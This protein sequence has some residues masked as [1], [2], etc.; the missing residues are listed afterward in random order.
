MSGVEWI[1]L[2]A[3]MPSGPSS[4]RVTLWRRM[5]AAGA[6]SL[7]N[8][9]WALPAS[10]KNELFMNEI[11]TYVREHSGS[12][13]IFSARALT[14]DVE[15]RIIDEFSKNIAEDYVEFID[16]C[17]DFLIEIDGEIRQKKF[18]FAELDENEA[19]LQKLTSWLRKIRARD[20][21]GNARAQEAGDIMESC[22]QILRAFARSVYANEGI[23][24]QESEIE[25]RD[26]K[27]VEG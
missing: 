11:F 16:K 5:K 2:L 1:L 18:T 8:G 27:P 26:E 12:A 21:L 17:K 10:A 13:S 24:V 25:Y 23:D 7:H 20:N 22:R 9:V 6:V 15:Q 4:I 14:P 19:E 3:Q